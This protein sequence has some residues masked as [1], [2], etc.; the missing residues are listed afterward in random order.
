ML[1]TKQKIKL[2][3][4]V[5]ILVMAVRTV[6]GR[7]SHTRTTRSG[8]QWQLDL[9]EGID[10]SIWLL[11]SFEPETVR[12]HRQIVRPGDVVLDI[13]ANIGA[14]TLFLAQEVGPAGRVIAFE[15]TDYAFAKLNRNVGLN[16]GLSNRVQCLQFLLGEADLPGVTGKPLYSSWPLKEEGDLHHLHQGRLMTT[17]GASTRT[18]DSAIAGLAL[19]RVDCI[20]LDIDGAECAMLRGA[21]QVLTRWHPTIIMELAPYVLE[22]KGTS[23]GELVGLLAT[24]G[25]GLADAAS[26][27]A[28]AMDAV[29]LQALI[30]PGASLNVVARPRTAAAG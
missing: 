29:A 2:A 18:L 26:G 10:F 20:K 21:S 6:A 19:P 11:G 4:L 12:C 8:L 16:P 1:K 3:R 24:H 13:G 5:Q 9:N 17:T 28:L 22:E 23:L 7:G 30:P 14:H 15:P 25:Y 27:R